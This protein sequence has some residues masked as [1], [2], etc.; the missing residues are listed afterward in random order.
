M[1]EKDPTLA[2]VLLDL[3]QNAS[4][5]ASFDVGEEILQEL[6]ELT[7]LRK[8]KV[9]EAP[10]LVLKSPD[11]PSVLIETAFISNR[12][13]EKNLSSRRYQEHLALA[14]LDGIRDYFY[15]NPPPGTRVAEL[16]AVGYRA[17]AQH[18]IQ[19]GDTLSKIAARYRVSVRTIRALN[20]LRGDKIVVGQVLRIPP[21][22]QET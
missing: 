9:Q 4:L 8:R 15:A 5:S 21:G 20:D 22:P 6:G 18:V 7:R 14:I 11:V 16:R 13:D 2:S 3:S 17:R 1:A 12:T 19:R 10:F